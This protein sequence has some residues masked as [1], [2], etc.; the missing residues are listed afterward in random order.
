MLV[1]RDGSILRTYVSASK[2]ILKNKKYFLFTYSREALFEILKYNNISSSNEIIL[3]DYLCSTVIESILPFTENIKFYKINENLSFND[4]EI[5]SLISNKTKLIVFVDYFGVETK[6]TKQLEL[7]L[8]NNN[9]IIVKDSAHSFLS[10]VN[11]DFKKDYDYDYLISSVYKNLPL[12]VGSI[13]IGNLNKSF[14]FINFSVFIKRCAVLFIK[15]IICFLGQAKYINTDIEHIK[16]SDGGFIDYSYGINFIK[17]YKTVLVHINFD[18]I[19]F[20][21]QKLIKE[22]NCALFDNLMYK[23]LFSQEL[24]NHNIL[25]AYPII[26]SKKEQRDALLSL[27]RRNCVDAYTWPTFHEINC[28]DFLWNK[29][30]LLP[31]DKKVLK[32]LQNV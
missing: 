13:A 18:K 17:L 7:E 25:Q 24:I 16:L 3:P 31:I 10:L 12:Q 20:E 32:I 29:I 23:P 19:I 1:S 14:Y 22:F 30:V 5:N 4:V 21:K 6:I 28:N 2:N 11:R 9:V 8:K 27:L 15:N 26:C